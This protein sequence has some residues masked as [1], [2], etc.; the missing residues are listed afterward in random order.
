MY[1]NTAAIKPFL[2]YGKPYVRMFPPPI[3][4]LFMPE[5]NEFADL[6]N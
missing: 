4:A 5:T 3:R 6:C 1:Y 2:M